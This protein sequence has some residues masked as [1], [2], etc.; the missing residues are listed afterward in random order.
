VEDESIEANDLAPA[1]AVDD[2]GGPDV[3]SDMPID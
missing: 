3:G 1:V 2:S